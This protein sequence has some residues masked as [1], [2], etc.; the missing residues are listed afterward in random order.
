[1]SDSKSL[2]MNKLNETLR[3]EAI[4]MGLCQQWQGDWVTNKSSADLIEMY[5]RGIDFCFDREWPS[6]D[7]IVTQFD[8]AELQDKNVFIRT[9]GGEIV[10]SN[11]VAVVRECC[12]VVITIPR[13]AVVTLHCQ[14]NSNLSIKLL[15]GAKAFIHLHDSTAEIEAIDTMTTA[16]V[17]QYN[18]EIEVVANG[19][20]VVKDGSMQ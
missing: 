20:V 2:N 5:K 4:A 17:Y 13:N 8:Q 15:K 9:S 19:N 10:L 16:K 14:R 7:W 3:A 12:N 6:C 18:P 11:G 1:M